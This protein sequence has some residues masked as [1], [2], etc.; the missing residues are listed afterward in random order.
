M[1]LGAMNNPAKG[2]YDEVSWIVER[3]DF[4]DLTLEPPGADAAA[5]KIDKLK[6]ALNGKKIVGH[7]AWYLPFASPYPSVRKAALDELLKCLRVF[8]QLECR[9]MNVHIGAVHRFFRDDAAGWYAEI[10]GSVADEAKK[11]GIAIMVEHMNATERHL[12]LVEDILKAVPEV[13]F[14]LDVGHANIGND[15]FSDALKMLFKRFGKKLAH[16][17]I[18]DNN[19]KEDLHLPLGSGTMNVAQVVQLLRS[20]YDGTITLEVFSRDR[21]YILMNAKKFRELWKNSS[22]NKDER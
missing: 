22:N 12:E 20:K 2:V 3:F 21:D 16:V 8:S 1:Q 9:L 10:L 6:A 7:T 15:S 17:H 11:S 14:H 19:G 18:S 13:K 4:V 5:I